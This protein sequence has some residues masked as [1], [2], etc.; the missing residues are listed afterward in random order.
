MAVI[1]GVGGPQVSVWRFLIGGACLALLI[2]GQPGTWLQWL[3]IAVICGAVAL[4]ASW[5][6]LFSRP[7]TVR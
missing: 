6:R 1:S 5:H 7:A 3:A 4:E 2:L